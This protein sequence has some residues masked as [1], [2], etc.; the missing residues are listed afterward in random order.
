MDS[1]GAVRL[2]LGWFQRSS[3]STPEAVCRS[4]S[5]WRKRPSP[6][7]WPKRSFTALHWP[8]SGQC[9][10]TTWSLKGAAYKSSRAWRKA[11]RW[12]SACQHV[13]PGHEGH[14]VLLGNWSVLSS[15][16]ATHGPSGSRVND[17]R[18]RRPSFSAP[19]R[20]RVRLPSVAQ[21][22][23]RLPSIARFWVGCPVFQ[24]PACAADPCPASSARC[25]K[26]HAIS[27]AR[28]TAARDSATVLAAQKPR[29]PW[30]AC[31][32]CPPTLKASR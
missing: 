16:K 6:T 24:G 2:R 12:G 17:T 19:S 1:S 8:R 22:C 27:K 20:R 29:A 9:R 15:C 32:T 30:K 11:A 5:T 7:G 3:A 28:P 14:L 13:V 10:V 18:T 4:V 23:C 25:R 26:V 31:G 21:Q